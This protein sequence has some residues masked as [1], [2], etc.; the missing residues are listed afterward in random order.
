MSE[1]ISYIIEAEES[2]LNDIADI[3]KED[4]EQS[5]LE[6]SESYQITAEGQLHDPFTGA[7]IA[8]NWAITVI[9]PHLAWITASNALL[10]ILDR[11]KKKPAP[12]AQPIVIVVKNY[13]LDSKAVVINVTQ[14]TPEEIKD[15]LQEIKGSES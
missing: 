8:V 11:L 4:E 13:H 6:V 15:L 5:K 10:S 12:P 2:V 3:V 1:E 14:S 9:T 7:A